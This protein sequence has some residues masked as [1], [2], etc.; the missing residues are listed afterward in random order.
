[1][2]Q[3]MTGYQ[4]M[5]S[6]A[7]RLLVAVRRGGGVGVLVG[8]LLLPL[9]VGAVGSGDL[10]TSFGGDGTVLTD[11][12]SGSYDGLCPG[13]SARW[14]DRGGR[15][16]RCQW[17]PWTL[18]WRAIWPNGTLD[19]TF[20]GDG[21]CSPTSGVA[22]MTMPPPWPFSPMARLWWP[23]LHPVP[24]AP[25]FALARYLPNGTLD[26]TFGGDG[27]V[28]TDFGSGSYDWATALA[29]QP[30]GKIV[31]AGYSNASGS[32]TLPWRA[33][34]PTAPWIPPSAAMAR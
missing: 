1:M 26:T 29:I 4:R 24:V 7:R 28:L 17:Q 33:I 34:C 22:V 9:H 16:F 27:T 20:G 6:G 3:A 8:L 30:D 18:P 10:D 2:Q 19:T 12:G 14:Q 11:F 25:D 23:A 5:V 13:H 31:V 32:L 15:L 21:R